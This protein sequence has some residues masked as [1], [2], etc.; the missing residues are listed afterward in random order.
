M[1]EKHTKSCP[2]FCPMEV[3]NFNAVNLSAFF[4]FWLLHLDL[5][6]MFPAVS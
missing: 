6:K 5:K 3:L 4:F 1:T 2:V